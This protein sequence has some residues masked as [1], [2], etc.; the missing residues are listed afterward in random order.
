MNVRNCTDHMVTSTYWSIVIPTSSMFQIVAAYLVHVPVIYESIPIY[1]S[2]DSP[3]G[4]AETMFIHTLSHSCD[5]VSFVS[6]VDSGFSAKNCG[7]ID[8]NPSR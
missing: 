4:Y 2:P 6:L 1:F 3:S 8:L 7:N 5:E